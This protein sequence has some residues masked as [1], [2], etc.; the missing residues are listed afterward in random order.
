MNSVN[1]IGN[2][3]KQPELK[4]FGETTLA[5]LSLAFNKRVKKD[6][7]WIDKAGYVEVTV[8]GKQAESCAKHLDKGSK[9]GVS[10]ELEWSSWSDNETGKTRSKLTVTAYRVDFLSENK[11][12]AEHQDFS[13]GDRS[14]GSVSNSMSEPMDNGLPF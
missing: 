2:L 3:T 4:Q 1:I 10:G 8:F 9:V 13:T 6:G 11:T 5:N 12:P 14:Q 7:D